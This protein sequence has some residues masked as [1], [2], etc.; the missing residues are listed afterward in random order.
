MKSLAPWVFF[1]CSIAFAFVRLAHCF[2]GVR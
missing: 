1:V 2:G